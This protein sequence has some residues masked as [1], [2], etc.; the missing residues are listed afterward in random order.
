MSNECLVTSLRG[1]CSG[2]L[3]KY[4]E[5]I[6]HI[7]AEVADDTNI[8]TVHSPILADEHIKAVGCKISTTT[9]NY[10]D[11]ITIPKNENVSAIYISDYTEGCYLIFDNKYTIRRVISNIN[12]PAFNNVLLLSDILN[13]QKYSPEATAI[14]PNGLCSLDE[15]FTL[16][17]FVTEKSNVYL[18][19]NNVSTLVGTPND[20]VLSSFWGNLFG[21]RLILDTT[22]LAAHVTS[23]LST[24]TT[25]VMRNTPVVSGSYEDFAECPNLI[26][27]NLF[28]QQ[29]GTWSSETLKPTST[30]I[31]SGRFEF[32]TS[33]DVDRF[34][35]NQSN[36]TAP[37]N[38][39]SD[40]GKI[41]FYNCSRTSASDAAVSALEALGFTIT[42]T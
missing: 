27:L 32:A 20:A 39:S 11:A 18:G 41:Q 21:T 40:L 28:L 12:S 30:K 19:F 24:H 9:S 8:L 23:R 42:F 13:M 31:W 5:G 4:G 34:L 1:S 38:I 16:N 25:L 7:C 17:D 37:A 10:T 15:E 26:L 2:N 3:L 22:Y 29:P 35:I 14:G 33:G 6:I 36:C